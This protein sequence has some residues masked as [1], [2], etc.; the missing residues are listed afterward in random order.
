MNKKFFTFFILL[1]LLNFSFNILKQEKIEVPFIYQLTNI[2]ILNITSN[3]KPKFLVIDY[4]KDGTEEK[5]FNPLEI[6]T[7]K[8][9][10]PKVIAYLSIGEAENYRW[11]WKKEY[12]KNPPNWLGPENKNWPGNYKV[13]YWEDDWKNIVFE[14][15]NKILD[16]GFDG[17]YLDRIDS[18]KFW[19]E[20]GYEISFTSQKMIELVHEIYLYVKDRTDD[21]LIIPQ[22]GEDI[23][24]FDFD[25]N[26][27]NSISGIGIESLFYFI[28]KKV[29]EETLNERLN[30]ILKF[31]NSGKFVLVTNYIFD[32]KNPD[33]EKI[34]DFIKFCNKYGFYGYPANVDL[35]LSDISGALKYFDKLE[36]E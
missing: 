11:Y 4:S 20:N 13:K 5:K 7:L 33:E 26:Y 30:Y 9:T 14:Y 17:I 29:D 16:Q 21:F 24:E 36:K 31:K 34:L 12:F 8:N 10:G 18:Y 22:N 23:I 1:P 35:K 15:I 28:G 19:Y 3:Y 27:I 6:K 32:P 2:K 25:K